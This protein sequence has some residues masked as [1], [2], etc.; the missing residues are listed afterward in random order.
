VL[1]DTVIKTVN[2]VERLGYRQAKRFKKEKLMEKV[3]QVDDTVIK[4]NLPLM[5][6]ENTSSS[7]KSSKY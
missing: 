2:E 6:Y 3:M 1:G 5:L 4:N 7:K